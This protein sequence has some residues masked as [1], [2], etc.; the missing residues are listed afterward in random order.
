MK[1][2]I[3]LKSGPATAEA[4]RA[5]TV[6]AD[7]LSQG[8]S[9]TLFL[10]QDAVHLC[11][12]GVRFAATSHLQMLMQRQMEVQ[13][14]KPDCSLRGMDPQL[15]NTP[16]FSGDYSSLIDLLESSDRVIGIL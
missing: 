8:H 14:L 12:P 1:V 16:I 3:L 2:A 15:G 5:L 13:V 11:R 4:E 10:L 7:L 9:V 6:A